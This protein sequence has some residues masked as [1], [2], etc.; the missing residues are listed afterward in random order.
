MRTQRVSPFPQKAPMIS[1][2]E[3]SSFIRRRKLL[4]EGDRK[5]R[6]EQ[7][8]WNGGRHREKR[9]DELICRLQPVFHAVF[10]CNSFVRSRQALPF[11]PDL[12]L[13]YSNKPHSPGVHL[14]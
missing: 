12:K 10:A 11:P 6:L 7:R 1:K 5:I 4:D 8:L 14:P 13:H 2:N 3:W 9:Q